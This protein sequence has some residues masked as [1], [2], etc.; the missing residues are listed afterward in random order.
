M[1]KVIYNQYGNADVLQIAEI[2]LPTMTINDILVKVKAVSINPLD[3]KLIKGEMKMMSGSKF[4]KGGGI[5]FSGIIE[6]AGS[7]IS[8]F[9]KGEEVFGLTN[10]FK[11][12]ALAEYI[13]V[14]E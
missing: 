1:K 11:G 6:K 7:N 8:K 14:G 3:W 10:V 4:P 9:K 12:S 13:I 5:D 2:S